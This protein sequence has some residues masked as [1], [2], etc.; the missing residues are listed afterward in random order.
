MNTWGKN[1]KCLLHK[2]LTNLLAQASSEHAIA[3][4]IHFGEQ[5]CMGS[6]LDKKHGYSIVYK[7]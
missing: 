1:S 3:L 7:R 4:H 2:D 6:H 5:V